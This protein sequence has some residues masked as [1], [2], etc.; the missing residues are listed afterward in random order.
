MAFRSILISEATKIN[1]D[2]NNI[3]IQYNGD[4]YHIN[5]DEI[6]NLVLDDARCLV[7]L[8]LLSELCEKGINVILTDSSHKPIGTLTTL[9]IMLELP[10][11]IKNK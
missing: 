6:S 1:L 3:V 8:R 7:S 9:I 10:K 4:N 11:K 5:I 2:L